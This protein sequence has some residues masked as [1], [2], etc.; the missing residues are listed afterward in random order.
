V[1]HHAGPLAGAAL[2]G[3][4]AGSLLFGVLGFLLAIPL[5]VK[6]Y[7]RFGS[8]KAPAAAL[9][10]FAVVFSLSTFVIGPAI[11]GSDDDTS[12]SQPWE[13]PGVSPVSPPAHEEHH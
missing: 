2:L 3:G 9:A 10:L 5:L 6:L 7:R 1:L 11:T 12:S 13:R 8:W 4:I